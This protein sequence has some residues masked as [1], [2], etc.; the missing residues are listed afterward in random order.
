ME[1][2]VD[3]VPFSQDD[4]HK[5]VFTITV[6]DPHKSFFGNVEDS[7]MIALD[8]CNEEVDRIETSENKLQDEV[9]S[10]IHSAKEKTF[11]RVLDNL[12]FAIENEFRPKFKPIC[13]E[14]YNWIYDYQNDELKK[15]MNEF[16][17]QRTRYYFDNDPEMNK[18]NIPQASEHEDDDDYED[19][20]E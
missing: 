4:E 15:W 2:K 6:S 14:I 20:D 1:I 9:K 17:P 12:K 13:Q 19:D 3:R 7:I 11:M 5:L 16:N 10:L 18:P 8:I